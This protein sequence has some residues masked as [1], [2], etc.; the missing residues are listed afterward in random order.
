LIGR[1]LAFVVALWM[2][3]G[4]ASVSAQPLREDAAQPAPTA[5]ERPSDVGIAIAV[6]PLPEGFDETRD[7]IV[8]WQFP[9]A[10]RGLVDALR[11]TTRA[12]L[13]R[14][15]RDL[16]ASEEEVIVRVARD[17][18]E[19]RACAPPDAPPPSYAVGV[20]Y[21]GLSL[22]ILTLS[23]P[24]T[25]ERPPVDRVLVHEWSHVSL[26]RAIGGRSVP[27]WFNEGLAI[28]EARERSMDRVRTL[29]E[30]TVRDTLIPLDSLSSHFPARPHAVDLAYAESA[31]FVGWL[32]ERGDAGSTEVGRMLERIADGQR[33][34]EAISQTFSAGIG[35]LEDEWR[36]ELGRRY[37]ALPL[38]LG[39]SLAWIVVLVLLVLAYRRRRKDD[40]RTLARWEADEAREEV[41]RLARARADLD[42]LRAESDAEVDAET[43]DGAPPRPRP[44]EDGVPRVVHDGQR[45]TLH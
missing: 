39:S 12:D 43:D 33:F 34:E 29:W 5:L 9:A 42:A 44:P 35:Q 32:F 18:D 31:D 24:T 23:A 19:M 2:M 36:T 22:I 37:A 8:L 6:P 17:P 11:D 28:H 1:F 27:L 10:A 45:H 38:L 20:A 26:H 30:A 13:T 15:T 7:G 25:W 3:L 21:P 14:V 40:A 41:A 16:G 4:A